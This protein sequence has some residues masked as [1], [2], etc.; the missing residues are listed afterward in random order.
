MLRKQL[1]KLAQT[2]AQLEVEAA[3]I[4]RTTNHHSDAEFDNVL[5]ARDQAQRSLALK[6]AEA[7]RATKALETLKAK[8]NMLIFWKAT[9][10]PCSHIKRIDLGTALSA[11]RRTRR[12]HTTSIYCMSRNLKCI[13]L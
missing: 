2:N 8:Y 10:I 6:S 12:A 13:Y 9:L 3:V 11:M 1:S 7:D 5:E 4:R